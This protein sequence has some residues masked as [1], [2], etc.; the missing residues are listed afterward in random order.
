MLAEYFL[1]TWYICIYIIS[2]YWDG[3]GTWNP[4]WWKARKILFILLSQR[5][6]CWW[7]GDTRI[8]DISNHGVDLVPHNHH[9]VIKWKHFL[10]YWPFMRGIHRW[11][12]NSPH[13][14]QWCRALMFSLLCAW[15]NSWVNNRGASDLRR[16]N[17]HY[18]FTVMVSIFVTEG[19]GLMTCRLHAIIYSLQPRSTLVQVMACCLTAPS[20]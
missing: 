8:L 7:P 10:H 14:G 5:R 9:D 1:G 15:I 2:G 17:A 12:V 19:N 6:G 3:T 18:D 20:H 16:H 11:P 13:K 4:S